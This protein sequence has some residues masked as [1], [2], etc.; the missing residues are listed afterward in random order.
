M[1][2]TNV[3]TV[4]DE[5]GKVLTQN[6]EITAKWTDYFSKLL[7]E[8]NPREQTE[9][10]LP[11]FGPV[12]LITQEVKIALK[13]MKIK[14]AANADELPIEVW[15]MLDDV[16]IDMLVKILKAVLRVAKCQNIGDT[17]F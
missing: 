7:N 12:P 2:V 6:E 9:P 4:K 3:K 13:G 11:I 8:E 14:K 10:S 16:G 5:T 17:V 1:D 15:K